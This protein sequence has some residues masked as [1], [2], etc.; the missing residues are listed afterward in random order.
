[1]VFQSFNTRRKSGIFVL[2]ERITIVDK[3]NRPHFWVAVGL[4]GLL[5]FKDRKNKQ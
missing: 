3:K 5:Y 4:V 1:M 2:W